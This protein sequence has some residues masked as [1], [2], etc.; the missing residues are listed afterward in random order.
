MRWPSFSRRLRIPALRD[1]AQ[2]RHDRVLALLGERTA[3][4]AVF[5]DTGDLER[6][7]HALGFAFEDEPTR[8][9]L[10]SYWRV[11]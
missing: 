2:E 10:F 7:V 11:R 5:A 3:R 6:E 8:P 4:K 1:D 9:G